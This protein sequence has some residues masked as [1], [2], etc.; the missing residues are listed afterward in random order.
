MFL[1]LHQPAVAISH[2]PKLILTNAIMILLILT[3]AFFLASQFNPTVLAATWLGLFSVLAVKASHTF[4]KVLEIDFREIMIH[5]LRTLCTSLAMF[6]LVRTAM[7][8]LTGSV[9]DWLNLLLSIALGATFYLS[10]VYLTDKRL[11][12]EYAALFKR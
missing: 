9:S 1:E 6:A 2:K 8:F 5:L 7:H 12:H 3:P 4:C 11:F 10:T